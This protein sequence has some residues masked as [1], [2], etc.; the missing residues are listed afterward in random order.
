MLFPPLTDL[1]ALVGIDLVLCAAV[2]RLVARLHGL[3]R[4]TRWIVVVAV[5]AIMWFPVGAARLPVLA[6]VRGVSSDLSMTLVALACF[7]LGRRLFGLPAIA[8]REALAL[9]MA[10]AVAAAVLYPTALGWGDWDAYQPGW[11]SLGMLGI[12]LMLSLAFWIS[13]LRLLPALVGLGLLAWTL[14]LMESSNLWDYLLDPWLAAIAVIQSIKAGVVRLLDW[15]R[16]RT[17]AA[18]PSPP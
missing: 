6:I 5:F 3:T 18:R 16:L 14:G 8:R 7:S 17:P 15:F 11:G 4:Q 9:F 1:L 12:L 10:L 13:G 2:L